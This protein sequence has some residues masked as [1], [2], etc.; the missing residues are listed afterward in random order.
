MSLD[1]CAGMYSDN[2]QPEPCKEW[3]DFVCSE[4]V[5]SG[6]RVLC[7]GTFVGKFKITFSEQNLDAPSVKKLI[8]NLYILDLCHD[9][10][11]SIENEICDIDDGRC[12]CNARESCNNKPW[13]PT[14][15]NEIGACTCGSFPACKESEMCD[16]TS[17]NCFHGNIISIMFEHL[18]SLKF[19][20]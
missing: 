17:G 19:P 7:K 2:C 20:N 5:Y 18:I 13:A 3:I 12:K 4:G 10:Q 8:A 16:E 6:W 15:N 9:I 11:C 1:A 14:C